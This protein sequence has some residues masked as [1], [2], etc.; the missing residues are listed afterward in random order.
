MSEQHQYFKYLNFRCKI[1]SVE[2]VIYSE[3]YLCLIKLGWG[4]QKD[5]K[6]IQEKWELTITFKEDISNNQ[7]SLKVGVEGD[8]FRPFQNNQCPTLMYGD[9]SCSIG[10]VKLVDLN[11]F[12]SVLRICGPKINCKFITWINRRRVQSCFIGFSTRII[13][14]FLCWAFF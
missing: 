7:S 6:E 13:H 10:M 11:C 1:F 14:N 5:K 12:F 9:N 2:K 4:C 8:N 3:I